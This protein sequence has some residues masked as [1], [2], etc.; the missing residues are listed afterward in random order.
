MWSLIIRFSG[1]KLTSLSLSSPVGAAA[2]MARRGAVR[3]T[4]FFLTLRDAFFAGRAP[5]R[6][7]ATRRSLLKLFEPESRSPLGFGQAER[8]GT[9]GS[10]CVPQRSASRRPSIQYTD[11]VE[12]LPK[13]HIVTQL[14]EPWIDAKPDHGWIALGDR[15]VEQRQRLRAIA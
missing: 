11:G 7:F 3:L 6:F 8:L 10:S 13:V 12:Q 1:L 2:A 14:V 5:L 15:F 9:F 4:A